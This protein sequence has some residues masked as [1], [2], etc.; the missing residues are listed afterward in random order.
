MSRLNTVAFNNKD[1]L[2]HAAGGSLARKQIP[3]IPVRPFAASI[4]GEVLF[5]LAASPLWAVRV[6]NQEIR[7]CA[8]N[9]AYEALT[10]RSAEQL[11]G[12]TL[13]ELWPKEA[14]ATAVPHYLQAA[15]TGQSVNYDI[16][17]LLRERLTSLEVTVT[18][19]P[20]SDS[21][22]SLLCSARM[23]ND[24]MGAPGPRPDNDFNTSIIDSLDR[25]LVVIDQ[26]GLVLSIN[27]TCRAWAA[28]A[29]PASEAASLVGQN[30][31][32]HHDKLVQYQGGAFSAEIKHG[33]EAV[34]SGELP[35]F[36]TDYKTQNENGPRYFHL[37]VSP[38]HGSC[39][40]AVI[41][42]LET[43]EQVRADSLRVL[44]EG[45]LRESQKREALGTLSSGIAHEFNNLIAV[46]HG[47]A[48]LI[49]KDA[50]RNTK[51]LK[52]LA[53]VQDACKSA[54]LMVDQILAFGRPQ[55]EDRRV[56]SLVKIV[57]D[58]RRLLEVTLP[59]QVDLKISTVGAAP[60]VKVNAVQI[61]QVLLNLG[62]N[63][64]HALTSQQGAIRMVI[65]T[66][67]FPESAQH[68]G[69]IPGRFGR[70]TVSDT[71]AGMDAATRARVFEPFFTTKSS[72]NNGGLGL[73]VAHGIVLSHGGAI[74][75]AST[76]G[77]GSEFSV[78]L[79][80]A[81]D[82]D[83]LAA[84]DEDA[85]GVVARRVSRKGAG[86]RVLYID[87]QRWLVPLISRILGEQGYEVA[88]FF[89]SKLAL[90]AIH[91]DPDQFDIVVTDYK[92][93][94]V[95]GLDIVRAVKAARPN[96]PT[97]LLSGYLPENL[98]KQASRSGVDAVIFKPLL[99][100][101]LIPT[102]ARLLAAT[103]QGTSQGSQ[104]VDEQ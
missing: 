89:D 91:A 15:R 57:E 8:V 75:V 18:P 68:P 78:Y 96:T 83:C 32:E 94:D 44:L 65:D 35:S 6:E 88:G 72:G 29:A 20:G 98:E 76:M 25:Q 11:I 60:Y 95:S 102:V 23:V 63:A 13:A 12:H 3:P 45:Q 59:G 36:A 39:R 40:G 69:V 31:F 52:S 82:A 54:A 55:P 84:E 41:A 62:L 70:I 43:T 73:S 5:K 56:G 92:M 4:P 74:A 99:T 103:D 77:K 1:P 21:G 7:Y 67:D 28:R 46:I 48:G 90:A 42:H 86:Q 22:I 33:I 58:T 38:L 87:D 80:L 10:G 34:L 53:V 51:A 24:Q 101:E 49:Q 37:S 66:V 30:Y 93:P 104:A 100:D 97:I 79:P 9:P 17:V 85:R 71:G 16:N 81:S 19:L 2:D 14:V 27:A 50:R 26:H 47:Y 61:Q 64:V